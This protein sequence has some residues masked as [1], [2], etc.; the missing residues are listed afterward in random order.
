LEQKRLIFGKDTVSVSIH[1]ANAL[2]RLKKH[3]EEAVFDS[4]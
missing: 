2:F 4:K 1:D 3:I